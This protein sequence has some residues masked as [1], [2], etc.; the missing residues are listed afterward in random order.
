[1]KVLVKNR[2]LSDILRTIS[3]EWFHAYDRENLKIKDRRDI[4]G[5]S[6]NFANTLSGAFVKYYVKKNPEITDDMYQ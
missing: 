3:H 2:M 4:G 1:M 5:D 6:E